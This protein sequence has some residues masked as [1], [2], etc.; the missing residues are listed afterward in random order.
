[1]GLLTL[2]DLSG[3]GQ[4]PATADCGPAPGI[5]PGEKRIC[6]PG[7]G[8]VIYT[9]GESQYGLC[10]RARARM[11]GDAGMAP[12]PS[13][14]IATVAAQQEAIQARKLALEERREA[15]EE[16]RFQEQVQELQLRMQLAR[17]TGAQQAKA[18]KGAAKRRRETARLKAIVDARRRK[19]LLKA[20]GVG[21]VIYAAVK[22]FG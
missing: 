9:I 5:G 21:A 18:A 12:A 22:I 6:C 13:G 15:L 4:F 3:L 7:L 11:V 10:E 1:M 8:W 2:K 20:A 17:V 19:Q 14:L 16:Q